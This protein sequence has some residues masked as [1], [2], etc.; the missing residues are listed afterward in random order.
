[1]ANSLTHLNLS[2]CG[3]TSLPSGLCFLDEEKVVEIKLEGNPLSDMERA[4]VQRGKARDIIWMMK[5]LKQGGF[6]LKE[7][8]VL[9]VGDAAVGKTTLLRGLRGESEVAAKVATDGIEIGEL[10][11]GGVKLYCWDFAGQEVYRYT[12]QLFLSDSA[13]YLVARL[14]SPRFRYVG[15]K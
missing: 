9:V 2:D 15:P 12:H 3:L 5:E 14:C 7:K 4:V 11:L 8:K 1:M 6:E 13:V 10:Y